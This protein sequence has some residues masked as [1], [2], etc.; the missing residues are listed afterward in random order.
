M[1]SINIFF[2]GEPIRLLLRSFE[3]TNHFGLLGLWGFVGLLRRKICEALSSATVPS[4][5]YLY[6]FK[7]ISFQ[8]QLFKNHLAG[9]SGLSERDRAENVFSRWEIRSTLTSI[10]FRYVHPV[11]SCFFQM[12][13]QQHQSRTLFP[14]LYDRARVGGH[15]NGPSEPGDRI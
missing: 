12:S 4:S 9:Y 6:S 3:V 7:N 10:Y 5:A 1:P 2:L 11:A 14:K 13:V 8:G 15:M